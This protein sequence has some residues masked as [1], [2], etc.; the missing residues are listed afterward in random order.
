MWGVEA[1]LLM[2]VDM[3][4]LP[5]V[6]HLVGGIE[7]VCIVHSLLEWVHHEQTLAISQHS[8]WLW[9]QRFPQV[10][11]WYC[12]S[13]FDW[14]TPTPCHEVLGYARVQSKT[15][16]VLC[17][18]FPIWKN[19]CLAC[20]VWS[21]LGKETNWLIRRASATDTAFTTLLTVDFLGGKSHIRKSA[22]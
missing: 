18:M 11:C 15:P 17:S 22:E 2:V 9:G 21:S 4:C 14:H 16:I 13:P 1:C 3:R 7:T 19:L 6:C 10:G 5:V 20:A 8:W 12:A